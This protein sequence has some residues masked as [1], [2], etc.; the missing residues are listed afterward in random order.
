MAR[1]DLTEVAQAPDIYV[2]YSAR[3][4]DKQQVSLNGLGFLYGYGWGYCGCAN[5]ASTTRAAYSGELTAKYSP[6][7]KAWSMASSV[8]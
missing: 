3:V 8:Q 5:S 7:A 2:A 4:E 6:M 1:K